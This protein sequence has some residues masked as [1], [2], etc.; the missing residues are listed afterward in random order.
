[1]ATIKEIKNKYGIA[2]Q[3]SIRI[4]PYKP[5]YKTFKDFLNPKK[6]KKDAQLWASKIE[7]DMLHGTFKQISSFENPARDKIS[8]MAEL[9]SYYKNEVAPSHYKSPEKYNVM[10]QWWVDKIGT[11]KLQD[12]SASILSAC[13]RDLQTEKI[14]KKNKK[15]VRGN[16][17]INK[18]LMCLSAILT[19]AVKEL[20][21]IEVNPLSK[22]GTLPKPDG[23][24]RFLSLDEIEKLISACKNHSDYLYIFVMLSLST[25]GRYSEIL[26]LKIENIDFQNNQV[27]FLNTKNKEDRGVPID[28]SIL[29]EV[30][31]YI[32]ENKIKS[33]LFLNKKTNKLYYIRGY[34]QNIIKEIGLNDFHIH[35][36]RHTTASYIAMNGGSLLDIAE[37]LGHKSLVMARRYSHL[38][39]KHTATVLS[40]VTNK[41][42]SNI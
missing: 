2:Y 22:V 6:A 24:K 12:L 15:V 4:K 37:I 9:I 40:R 38:T 31:K 25:G 42:L 10:F 32:A 21:L 30:K 28:I 27:Y 1:M 33:E 17:T 35:D 39:Q 26:N 29:Q 34:L 36:L 18:Y 5:V 16:N 8:T 11:I 41:I 7:Y 13:K 3:V 23:R 19:F 20:E 14:T